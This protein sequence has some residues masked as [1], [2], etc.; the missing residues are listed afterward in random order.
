[1]PNLVSPIVTEEFVTK[2]QND[3]IWLPM[4][5]DVMF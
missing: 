3:E 4:S 5:S 1:M 2:V